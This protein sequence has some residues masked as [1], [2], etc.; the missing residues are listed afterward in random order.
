LLD[1][2][3]DVTLKMEVACLADQKDVIVKKL[4]TAPDGDNIIEVSHFD[5]ALSLYHLL[6][7]KS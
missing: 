5:D 2:S 1:Q 4:K 7:P 6:T 3:S